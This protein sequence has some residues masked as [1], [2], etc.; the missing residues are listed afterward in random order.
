MPFSDNIAPV[1]TTGVN[2][3]GNQRR[4]ERI[5]WGTE[6]TPAILFSAADA[7]EDLPS[8]RYDF[9]ADLPQKHTTIVTPRGWGIIDSARCC[10]CAERPEPGEQH[11][12]RNR[13]AD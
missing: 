9:I 5:F 1:I 8:I 2:S 12:Y 4:A 7:R 13:W 10:R 6:N 3:V 11:S